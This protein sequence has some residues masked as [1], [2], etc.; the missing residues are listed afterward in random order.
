MSAV[1]RPRVKLCGVTRPADAVLAVELGAELVGLNFYPPSPRALS[2]EA[3]RQVADA[4]RGRAVLVG[5]FVNR[6]PG[7]VEAIAAAVGL[8]LLQFHGDETAADLAPFGRRALK[9]HRTRGELST[10][11]P[12]AYPQAWGFLFDMLHESLYGGTGVA[13]RWQALSDLETGGRPYLVAGGIGPDNVRRA[14]QESG[15]WGVDICSAV[16]SSPGV[17]DP[18]R[19]EALF[20]ELDRIHDDRPEEPHERDELESKEGAQ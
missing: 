12:A 9:V 7:E 3:A 10:F 19:L 1:R 4:V 13:W 8:D 11:D 17:K 15:A 14:V 6:P 16:E 2:A 20:A 5:V 18:A